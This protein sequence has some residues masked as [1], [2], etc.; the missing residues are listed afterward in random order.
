MVSSVLW[1]L[2]V[3]LVGWVIIG[4]IVLV[5]CCVCCCVLLVNYWVVWCWGWG[6]VI[7]VVVRLLVVLGKNLVLVVFLGCLL[8][9]E[10]VVGVDFV[11]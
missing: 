9:G 5:W 8:M 3:L 2:G 10:E 1:K 6:I 7:G 4:W 11:G